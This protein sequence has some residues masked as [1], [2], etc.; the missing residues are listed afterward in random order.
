MNRGPR[1]RTGPA[2]PSSRRS[3]AGPGEAIARD[4]PPALAHLRP[5]ARPPCDVRPRGRSILPVL[6]ALVVIGRTRPTPSGGPA[7]LE[8]LD[9]RAVEQEREDQEAQ[10]DA[11]RQRQQ[12]MA[13][14]IT[15]GDLAIFPGLG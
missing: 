8:V 4:D 10:R 11:E 6:A 14:A 5:P 2:L 7:D 9:A 3:Q 13:R 1:Q 15:F 12:L